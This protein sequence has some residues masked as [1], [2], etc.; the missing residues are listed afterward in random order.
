MCRSKTESYYASINHS[1]LMDIVGKYVCDDAV[2]C[3]LWGY[4]RRYVSDG[5]NYLDLTEGISK[6][7][8]ICPLIGALFLKPLDV[9]VTYI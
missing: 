5:G 4:L 9:S 6:G 1:F 7:C 2:L 3:L 8:P